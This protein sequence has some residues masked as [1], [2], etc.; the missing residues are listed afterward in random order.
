MSS[1]TVARGRAAFTILCGPAQPGDGAPLEA[2]ER[3]DRRPAS[4]GIRSAT[5]GGGGLTVAEP[6]P[7]GRKH[8]RRCRQ[9]GR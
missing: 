4:A 5:I 9:P 7:G 2:D 1:H 8:R 6:L 3:G